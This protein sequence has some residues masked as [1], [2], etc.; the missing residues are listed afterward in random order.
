MYNAISLFSGAMGL[1]L[2]LE[3]AGFNIRTCVEMNKLAA[4][5]IM[6]NTDIP[7]INKDINDVPTEE[8]LQTANL[9]KEEVFLVAGGP[10]CQAFS[11][12]GA[13]RALEDFRGNVI[14]NYLRVIKDIQPKFF[15][16]ENVRGI[17]SSAMKY[18]PEEFGDEYN[19]IVNLKG[20]VIYFLV[21]EFEKYGY[22]ISF[23][24][25]N[26]ANY[27]VPQKRERVIIFGH[28]GAR[29]PLPSPTHTQSGKE[30]GHRWT[31]FGQV[32]S[33]LK[34]EDMNY[35][36]LAEKPRKYLPFLK[37]GQYWKH[38]PGDVVEEAMGGSYRLGGGKTGFYR[39]LSFDEPS[40]TLVTSPS[41][42]AT[43]LAHPEHLRPLSI[44]EYARIQ[45]FPD[46]WEFE[47]GIREVYKQIGNAVPVGLGY[48]A[49]KTILDFYNGVYDKERESKN[50]IPYS[51]Y[52]NC[53]DFEFL[54]IFEKEIIKQKET[55]KQQ[56]FA[57]RAL[58]DEYVSFVDSVD[59]VK[60][61]VKDNILRQQVSKKFTP[62][63]NAIQNQSSKTKTT[64]LDKLNDANDIVIVASLISGLQ[65]AINRDL[66]N[67][68]KLMAVKI[69]LISASGI[70]LT[71]LPE[72]EMKTELLTLLTLEKDKIN[73]NINKTTE[74]E[75]LELF[76]VE[77]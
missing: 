10:P 47:G 6:A 35:I 68:A 15:I 66:T 33:G 19:D 65:E 14:I 27:G 13:R 4:K 46:D 77:S 28:K 67:P 8:I 21:K 58:V 70:Y 43:M 48:V 54:P 32:V 40:P 9:K 57:T 73:N 2:G 76:V 51:R 18:V 34:E 44:E 53:S 64:L 22:S 74:Y 37:G 49:G 36:E 55:Q 31:S 50:Q 75:Q 69:K 26:S 12:A 62:A 1:D 5:T 61:L 7:V 42:P 72:G 30:T 29:I 38:L 24:L 41:M 39:R 45:Q 52:K 71:S 23:S 20:S 3:K 17:L 60:S 11:T 25:F 16:L 56:L 59:K 63:F